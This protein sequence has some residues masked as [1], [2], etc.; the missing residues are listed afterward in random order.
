MSEQDENTKAPEGSE[1]ESQ[2]PQ[3]LKEFSEGM[4]K[5]QR[6]NPWPDPPPIQ[7]QSQDTSQTSQSDSSSSDASDSS[8]SPSSSNDSGGKDD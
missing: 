3:P 4:F 2:P 6:I 7:M 1:P 8:S 5:A